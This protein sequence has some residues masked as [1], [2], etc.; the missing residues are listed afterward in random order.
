MASTTAICMSGSLVPSITAIYMLGDLP[1]PSLV[2]V[3]PLETV[4]FKSLSFVLTYIFI[5]Q[6]CLDFL[7]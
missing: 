4:H 5:F 6:L 7:K 3:L 2:Q 1:L